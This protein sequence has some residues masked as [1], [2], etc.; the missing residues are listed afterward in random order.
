MDAG[1]STGEQAPGLRRADVAPGSTMDRMLR[2]GYF[3]D[4]F[5]AIWLLEKFLKGGTPPGEGSDPARE[6]I[7]ILPHTGLGFPATDVRKIELDGDD[8]NRA[9]VTVTFGGLYGIDSALPAY[10]YDSIATD[11]ER[12]EAL[13]DFLDIFNARLYSL[14][15]RTWK[16]RR[17]AL[18]FQTPGTDRASQRFL[19]LAGVG[20]KKA[21]V[22]AKVPFMCLAAHA[23]RLSCRVRNSEGLRDFL[24]AFFKDVEIRV[25]ENV[26][27]WVPITNRATMVKGGANRPVLGSTATIGT[28]IRDISGKFRISLGP[29]TLSQFTGFLPGTDEAAIL[30]S[31]VGLYAP[32]FLAYDIELSLQRSEIPPA[33]LGDRDVKL[34]LNAWAGKTTRSSA[35]RVVSYDG[36]GRKNGIRVQS[37]S[38]R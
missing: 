17:P 25:Q 20:T 27:R 12:T 37:R 34:G 29:L 38:A 5:Q 10:F 16:K 26:P 14:F 28:R 21:L 11:P 2:H 15:Y 22:G 7:T 31:L 36:P 13:R 35:S 9:R 32:D 23:G 19:C 4:F 8:G 6:R 24:Q 18:E 30:Q 3:F 1:Q 33:R